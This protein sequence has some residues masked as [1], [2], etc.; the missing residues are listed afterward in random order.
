MRKLYRKFFYVPKH[1]K[2][3]EN[4]ML[5]RSALSIVIMVVCLAAM[6]ITAY[7]YFFVTIT[8]GSNIIRAA[9]FEAQ[10]E[11]TDSNGAP[12]LP[13]SNEGA[14]NV[15]NFT[16]PGTYTVKLSKGDS[17][18]D[19]GFCIITVSNA[20][21]YTQQIGI[22]VNAPNGERECVEFILQVDGPESIIFESHWGTS[23]T[24]S[25]EGEQLTT[26]TIG[27]NGA[28]TEHQTDDSA[29]NTKQDVQQQTVAPDG[30]ETIPE[31]EQN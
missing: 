11:V 19:T 27:E 1:G 16:T 18:A 5:M 28:G 29:E 31:G 3:R 9:N 24:Y 8:S 20:K 4:V 17:T 13:A 26:V 14:E 7:A 2:V 23:S 10:I 25:Y 6:S 15:Y 12:V 21:Y 22:D 30:P